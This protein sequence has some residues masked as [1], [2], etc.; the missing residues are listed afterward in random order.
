M[1]LDPCE[2]GQ[3]GSFILRLEE[4]SKILVC[5]LKSGSY[6]KTETW[7]VYGLQRSRLRES[8]NNPLDRVDTTTGGTR[9]SIQDEDETRWDEMKVRPFR[10]WGTQFR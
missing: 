10:Q 4:P 8:P 2:T 7:V 9:S 3:R 6:R 5:M 1:D